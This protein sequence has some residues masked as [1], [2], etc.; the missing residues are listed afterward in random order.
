MKISKR[1]STLFEIAERS[2]SKEAFGYELADF[3]HEIAR[4]TSRRELSEAIQQEPP[5]LAGR[6]DD[7][8]VAD[9]WLA[10][11]AE[12]LAAHYGLK[13]PDWIWKSDRFLTEP[14]IHDAHSKKLK[15]WH[16]LKSATAFSR[17]NYFV[18]YQLPAIQLRRGRPRLS[19]AH[20][21]KMNRQRVA[22]YRAKIEG[23]L[24]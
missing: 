1:P 23:S 20:K 2:H 5:P 14:H 24:R 22:R 17:R 13:Y 12:L 6:F 18:D 11:L 7:G 19:E 10:A 8:A 3:E 16:I 9:T 4:A 21:R 15:V